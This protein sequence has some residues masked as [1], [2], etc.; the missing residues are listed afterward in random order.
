MKVMFKVG[1]LLLLAAGLYGQQQPVPYSHKTHL[2][3]GLKCNS[4]HKNADPGEI[5]GFP[6]ESF[7]MSCHQSV[8]ANSPHIQKVAA[9]A[10]EKTP[11]P[12][13]RVYRIPPYVYFSHRVHTE[14]GATC[15]TC[16]G[17]VS[18][19]DVLTKVVF[20]DH[21]NALKVESVMT[22]RPETL[23]E[24]ASIAYALNKMSV[25]GYRHIPVVER[26]GKPIGVL[27]VRDIVDFLVELF[28]DGVLNLPP[29]P[30]QAIARSLDGG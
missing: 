13:A 10:K 11:I 23:E 16:H 18:E 8:K 28:P 20:R 3:M 17:R 7:C 6:A 9:A 15:E 21:S 26:S 25:G 30:E 12:W 5:M 22:R 1:G 29:S 27:S 2:A 19:R 4:C 24:T 14:A